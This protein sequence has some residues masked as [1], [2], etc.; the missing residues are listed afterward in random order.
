MDYLKIWVPIWFVISLLILVG[1]YLYRVHYGTWDGHWGTE[2]FTSGGIGVF[3]FVAFIISLVFFHM[4][5]TRP[6]HRRH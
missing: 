1:R 4:F 3:A 2:I 5:R 6:K